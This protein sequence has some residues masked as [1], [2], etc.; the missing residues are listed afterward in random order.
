MS[1]P[2]R[3]VE[4]VRFPGTL[5]SYIAENRNREEALIRVLT[6]KFAL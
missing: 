5:G 2:H 3:Q 6:A 1:A 4:N